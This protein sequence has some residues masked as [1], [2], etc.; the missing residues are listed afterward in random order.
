MSNAYASLVLSETD[1][2][3]GD[4]IEPIQQH[5]PENVPFSKLYSSH[6]VRFYV[7]R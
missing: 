7:A 4:P 3:G 1:I 2:P 5:G 6:P